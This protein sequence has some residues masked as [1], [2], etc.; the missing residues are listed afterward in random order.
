MACKYGI[1]FAKIIDRHYA[2]GRGHTTQSKEQLTGSLRLPGFPSL[3]SSSIVK[4]RNWVNGVNLSFCSK[5]YAFRSMLIVFCFILF[6]LSTLLFALPSEAKVAGNCSNCHTMHNSQDGIS[7]AQDFDGSSFSFTG[8]PKKNLLIYNCLGCHS[9]TDGTTW[10]DNTTKAPIVFNTRE[11]LYNTE[12]GL[13]GGNFYWVKNVA[14][15]D[16][17]H[18]IFFPDAGEHMNVAPG[19]ELFTTCGTHSCHANLDRVVSGTG[20]FLDG[21]QGCE[22]CHLDPKHHA[23]DHAYLIGGLVTSAEQGWYRFLVG[24]DSGT[25]LNKGA[26]GYEDGDWQKTVS[27]NDHN[28][29]L[30]NVSGG[31]GFVSLGNTTTAFCTGCHQAFHTNQGSASP[32]LRHPSD[33]ELP[34]SGE[35]ASYIIYDPLVPVARPSLDVLPNPRVVT[36]GA[37][38]VMCLS[39]HRAHASPFFKMMRWDYKNLN[40]ST[41]LEGCNVCHSSKN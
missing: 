37:D 17:G 32:W 1:T 40:L 16:K 13:A 11:P 5:L 3:L 24:H 34:D 35:Y 23:N 6:A 31:Y 36:P 29:Y 14:N 18:N 28:E 20:T 2:M 38:M 7:V 33:A 4:S 12:Q 9:A 21:K 8:T 19:A 27:S 10:Q 39:C 41:A 30:G 15:S 25:I 22:K 26:E